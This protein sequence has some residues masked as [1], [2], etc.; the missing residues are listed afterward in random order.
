MMRAMIRTLLLCALVTACSKKD[1]AGEKQA[2]ATDKPAETPVD[3]PAEEPVATP[4][5][6][7]PAAAAP[8]IDCDAL[9]TADDVAKACGGKAADF[10][11]NKHALETGKAATTCV[12]TAGKRG[13]SVKLAVSTA[14]GSAQGA[15]SLL[16]LSKEGAK[17][18]EVGDAGYLH[19]R[20][21]P[22]ARQ[23]MHDLEAIKGR[24]WFKLGYEIKQGEKKAACSDE[25]LIELGK[26]VA[27][28]LP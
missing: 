3:K 9:L 25:G 17:P 26:T 8:T 7:E 2:E 13:A 27:G 28:R 16:E 15:K 4:P 22:A 6:D 10:A 14:P 5:A 12:R 24:V 1:D 11:I 21:V 18:A 19:V 20:E 23:T